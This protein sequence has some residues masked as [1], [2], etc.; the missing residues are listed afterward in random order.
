VVT[1]SPMDSSLVAATSKRCIVTGALL[2]G[3]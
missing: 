1:D 3:V 2:S